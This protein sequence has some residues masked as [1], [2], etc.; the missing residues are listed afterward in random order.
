M[1]KYSFLNAVHP[2]FIAALY[3]TYLKS[4][5]EVEPSWRAFFQGFDFGIENGSA[6]ALGVELDEGLVNENVYKEFQVIKLIDGYRTRGHLFTKTNPVR[7]RRI[8][9]PTLDIENFGLTV[10]DL[11]TVFKAGEIVG[12]GEASL[13]NILK[14]FIAV[15]CDRLLSGKSYLI[16]IARVKNHK[17][18]I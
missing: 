14:N 6:E 18:K 15:H 9:S 5:D 13:E 8:Y 10:H 16:C 1:D 12:I 7:N 11:K 4:P 2:S 3:D 17:E